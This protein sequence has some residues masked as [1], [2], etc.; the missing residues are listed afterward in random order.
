MSYTTAWRQL[1]LAPLPSDLHRK[2]KHFL[3]GANSHHPQKIAFV[4][5]QDEAAFLS[6]L[7]Q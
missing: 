1:W 5:L 4:I 3:F 7:R 2:R 6:Y